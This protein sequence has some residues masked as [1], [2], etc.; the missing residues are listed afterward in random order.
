MSILHFCNAFFEWELAGL[1]PSTLEEACNEHFVFQ[2]LQYLPLTYGRPGDGVL[3]TK[4]PIEQTALPVITLD[5][6]PAYTQ[7][8][9]WGYSLLAKAWAEEKGLRYQMPPWDIVKMVN[10]KTYSFSKSPLPAARLIFQGDPIEAGTVLKSCYGTAGR[11]LILSENPNALA[12]CEAEWKRGLPVIS[13]PFVDRL[14]DFSTQWHISPSGEIAYIGAT[15]CK[16]TKLGMHK[17]NIAQ[18]KEPAF[19]E[20]HRDFV[21][22]VLEEIALMGYFGPVGFDAMVYGNQKLQP[23]VE[24]NARK[25]MGLVALA[26][27]NQQYPGKDVEIAYIPDRDR[28]LPNIK[29]SI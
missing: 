5:Q 14:V 8:E 10:S 20:E 22:E 3:A 11:G 19:L 27:Q 28:L 13:E 23:I 17:S 6:T 4:L 2:Q 12:F 18:K 15:I 29:I 24:I 25:T 21:T 1:S 26:V 7:L 16:T 9:T